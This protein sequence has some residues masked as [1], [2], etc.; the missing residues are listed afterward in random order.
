MVREAQWI[1]WVLR[2]EGSEMTSHHMKTF[3]GQCDLV[4]AR[5]APLLFGDLSKWVSLS[6]LPYPASCRVNSL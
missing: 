6:R 1:D 5:G 3:L 4:V 2:K